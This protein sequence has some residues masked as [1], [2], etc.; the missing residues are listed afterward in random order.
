VRYRWLGRGSL[1]LDGRDRV[2]LVRIGYGSFGWA[3]FVLAGSGKVRHGPDWQL[4]R[5]RAGQ[6]LARCGWTRFGS[7][8]GTGQ[9][10]V[11]SVAVRYGLM[12]QFWSG[13]PGRGRACYCV[14]SFGL[15]RQ[16]RHVEPRLVKSLWAKVCPGAKG[17]VKYRLHHQKTKGVIIWFSS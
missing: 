14:V 13:G 11:Q 7:F 10:N 6:G 15:T 5:G 4:R 2:C 1:G 8:G 17:P 16:L 9:G 3:L 12:R